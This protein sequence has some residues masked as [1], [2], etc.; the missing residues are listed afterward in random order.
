MIVLLK[1][2]WKLKV[3]FIK[4]HIYLLGNEVWQVIDNMFSKIHKQG[5]L[6]YT[7]DPTFFS[8]LVFIIYKTDS[9]NKRKSHAVIDIRKLNNLVLFNSYSLLLQSKIIAKIQ[10]CINLAVCNAASFF[11][12]WRLYF[13]YCFMFTVIIYCSQEIF[14]VPI[15]RY[16]NLV[17][18]VQC[19]IDN[20]FYIVQ[21]WAQAYINDIVYGA[22][23]LPNLLDKLRTLFEIFLAYN[24][25]IS[26]IKSYLNYLNIVF[27]I[28]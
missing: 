8:F 2:S 5:C 27:L 16:N 13:D 6:E 23:L 11:Y 3:S 9:H 28:Q 22:K 15:I 14:Q 20:I 21:T 25:F 24:I 12:Q 10:R 17:V 4:L 1:P 18:Y 19:K 7:I 26:P